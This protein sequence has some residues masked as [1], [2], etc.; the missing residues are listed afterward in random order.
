[1]S[2]ITFIYWYLYRSILAPETSKISAWFVAVIRC[3]WKT[4]IEG[5]FRLH[6]YRSRKT[7][8]FI[9]NVLQNPARFRQHVPEWSAQQNFV[10]GKIVQR[11]KKKVCWRRLSIGSNKT[12]NQMTIVFLASIYELIINGETNQMSFMIKIVWWQIDLRY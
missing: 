11:L 5:H 1:M 3:C 12:L 10:E 9:I 6:M 7:W 8:Q 2:E 4:T